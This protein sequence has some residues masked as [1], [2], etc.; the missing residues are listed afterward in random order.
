MLQ[1]ILRTASIILLLALSGSP[2]FGEEDDDTSGFFGMPGGGPML[3]NPTGALPSQMTAPPE[4][5]EL[6]IQQ[7][8]AD[9]DLNKD[10][11][12]DEKEIAQGRKKG[13]QEPPPFK[14]KRLWKYSFQEEPKTEK[15]NPEPE[16][17][18]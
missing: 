16:P 8:E 12:V 13:W 17:T 14:R 7:E 5:T 3:R 18:L 1:K 15:E 11:I 4:P 9:W 10:G 2:A 6:L